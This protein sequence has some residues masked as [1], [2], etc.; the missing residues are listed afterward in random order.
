MKSKDLRLLL[1]LSGSRRFLLGSFIGALVSTALLIGHSLLL[2]TL[3]VGVIEREPKNFRNALLLAALWI[4]RSQFNSFFEYWCSMQ[5][6]SLKLQL[7][8]SIS[9]RLENFNGVSSSELSALLIKGSNSLDIYLGRFLPQMLGASFTPLAVITTIFLI[10]PLS[11]VVAIFTLPLIPIFG[12][13]I[14]KYTSDAV[15]KKWRSLGTLSS[16][17]EDSLKGFVTLKIFGRNRS[18]G[19]RIRQMGDQYTD[20]TM[21]VLR[22]SFLSALVLELAA[23]ISVALI[24]VEIGLRL[25]EGNISFLHG[26]TVL[27]LAPEV[28]LPLRSAAS[29]FHASADGSEILQK[30]QGSQQ[31][32]SDQVIQIEEDF[33]G[34][35]SFGWSDWHLY[36]PNVVNSSIS[37]STV[38]R[39]EV[40]FIVGES[41]IGKSSFAENLL[42][43]HFD[44]ELLV[45]K[46]VVD[47]QSLESLQR[48]LG[49]VPQIPH[50]APGTLREQ[51]KLVVPEISDGEIKQALS[52]LS[53]D[54][55]DLPHG[56]DTYLGGADEK[57]SELSGGQIRKIS[58]A[59]ALIRKP[60]LIIADEPTAD[61]DQV[62]ADVVMKA[63]RRAVNEGSAL[64][65][66]THDQDFI[67]SND[68]VLT[69][70]RAAL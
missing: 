45:D 65:C 3:I 35:Q 14:G 5:A 60:F 51:F 58:V 68:R 30:L 40:T 48:N 27:I 39:G 22:I 61:L 33:S 38:K 21:K 2:A 46:S 43:V 25:V 36:I 7:R 56:L 9:S 57:S 32:S 16:Y 64:I 53:L 69:F 67:M 49:W 42:G 70:E 66:I 4:L 59:R 12:A 52:E 24:A 1:T 26:L 41:G 13:L 34:S 55:S 47:R 10:D 20:E 28:Y 17:F 37:A 15:S 18:Q 8:S 50:L 63:L 44:C 19:L 54:L 11:A 29:L 62:S 6:A 23:T 31:V